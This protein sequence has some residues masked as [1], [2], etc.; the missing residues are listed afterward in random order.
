VAAYCSH[1]GTELSGRFCAKCGAPAP[2]APGPG[3]GG[4][5][6]PRPAPPPS[7]APPPISLPGLDENLAAALCYLVPIVTG[8]L[9]LFVEPYNRNKNVRFHAFQSIF[10]WIGVL[11][12]DAAVDIVFG[13]ILGGINSY[14]LL[15]LVWSVFRLAVL[16]LWLVLMYRAYMRQRWVLPVVGEMAQKFV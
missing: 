3:L 5:D 10:F 14:E 2:N 8:V 16:A 1:C 15:R 6:I 9:F 11:L 7:P 4:S 12:A 13:G